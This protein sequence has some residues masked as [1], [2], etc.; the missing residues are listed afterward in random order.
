[1]EEQYRRNQWM[2]L[3]QNTYEYMET[4]EEAQDKGT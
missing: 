1:H 3:S 4:M 2:A